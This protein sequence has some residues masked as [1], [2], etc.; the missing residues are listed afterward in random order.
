MP[1]SAQQFPFYLQ[2]AAIAAQG[3]ARSDDAVTR[4]SGVAALAQDTANG[5]VSPG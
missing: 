2:I 1:F 4:R 3:A 5:A